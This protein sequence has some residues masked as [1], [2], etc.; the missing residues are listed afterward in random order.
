MKTSAKLFIALFSSLFPSLSPG[1]YFGER[2]LEKSF[3][4]SEFFFEPSV[5]IPFGINAFR[6]TS[7]GLLD[8][9][10]TNLALNPAYLY[11]DTGRSTFMYVDFRSTREIRSS[12]NYVSPLEMRTSYDMSSLL[13]Y[14]RYFIT[15]RKELEP[16]FSGALLSRP[17]GTLF[18]HLFLGLT[19]QVVAQDEKY[20]GI[21]QDIYRSVI[22]YDYLGAK[23]SNESMPIIDRYSGS[24]DMHH[25]GHFATLLGGYEITPELQVGVKIGRATFARD[26][27]FGSKNLWEYAQRSDYTSYWSNLEDREQNYGHWDLRGGASYRFSEKTEGALS[28]GY[29]W[30]TATQTLARADSSLYG[31]GQINVGK[32]WNYHMTSGSTGQNWD[33]DGA[34]FYGGLNLRTKLDPSRILRV[35]YL[36]LRERIDLTLNGSLFDTSYGNSRSQYND[37][38]VYR[39][40]SESRLS[41]RRSGTG[42]ETADVHRFMASLDWEIE[43]HLRLNFGVQYEYRKSETGTNEAVLA[44]RSS[45]YMS[46]SSTYSYDYSDAVNEEKNLLWTF[47]STLTSFQV[48]IILTWKTSEKIEMMFGLNRKMASWDVEDITLALFKMREHSSTSGTKRETNF[49]ERYT[50]PRERVSDVTTTALW[51]LTVSPSAFFKIRFLVTPNFVETYEGSQ[52]QGLQW[53]IGVN[54]FP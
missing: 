40:Q 9:P 12:S 18:P 6:S 1:Q 37:T 32:N 43:S 4:R 39:Y 46:T 30:G 13:P 33:H 7:V 14:P 17:L 23:T 38:L 29:L 8:E 51:G 48:P 16:V 42:E 52:L 31:S 54:M 20:Y 28:A 36:Y 19:Y 15:T 53:W 26:G 49:G 47:R 24:D 45:R 5:L 34:L 35:H 22:G 21:P 3:E 11:A 25:V 27:S 50:I 44:R 10:L 2:V 41:D